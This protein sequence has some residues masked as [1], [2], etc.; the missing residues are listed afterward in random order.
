MKVEP[1]S[2]DG[3]DMGYEREARM[4]PRLLVSATERM[5]LPFAEMGDSL[6]IAK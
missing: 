5:E 4:I 3:F 2:V 6:K 1:S